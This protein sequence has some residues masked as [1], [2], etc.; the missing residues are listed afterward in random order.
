MNQL[1]EQKFIVTI[2]CGIVTSLLCYLEKITG[3]VYAAVIIAT[4]GAYIAGAVTQYI[5]AGS[6]AG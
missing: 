4:V 1:T 5:K 2:G 3:E 6:D